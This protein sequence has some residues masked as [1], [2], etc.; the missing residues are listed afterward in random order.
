AKWIILPLV[1][2]AVL[3]WVAALTASDGRLHISVLDIGQGDSILISKGNQQILIDGGPSA[4][5]LSNELGGKL[6]FWD[7]TIELVVSTHPD[8][9]HLTGLVEVLGRYKVKK[10]LTS[11]EEIDSDVYREWRKLIDEKG[12]ECVIAQAGQEIS[13][14][15]GVR[16]AVLNPPDRLVGGAPADLNDNSVVLRLEAKRFSML[17]TGDIGAEAEKSLLGENVELR[18]TVL[19][20]SHHG[21]NT[22]TSADFLA[23]VKP[24]LAVISVGAD[25]KF[26]HP[27]PEVGSRLQKAVGNDRLFLTSENGAI[28]F[29]TDGEKLW[30]DTKR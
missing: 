7:R 6:P 19:K 8:S 25:N 5:K 15:N 30:V 16:L 1:V 29:V 9:D 22:A 4:A 13:L 14:G 24:M 18:S 26:G 2:A 11:G 3:I 23:E 20:V 17:L 10:I 27:A 12:V 28:E 21:S